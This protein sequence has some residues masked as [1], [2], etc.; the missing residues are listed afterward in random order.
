[1]SST[2]FRLTWPTFSLPVLE[3]PSRGLK[4]GGLEQEHAGG[5]RLAD[6]GERAIRVDGDDDRNDQVLFGLRLGR[7][8][9]LLAEL[10]DVDAVLAERGPD[11]RRRIRLAGGNL[12]LDL[13][14]DSFI[15]PCPRSSRP[16]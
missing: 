7:G 10:H 16:A 8:V 4:S 1:M 5:R 2:C 14:C 3:A 9:E 15:A 6:E 13:S 11:R 12:K